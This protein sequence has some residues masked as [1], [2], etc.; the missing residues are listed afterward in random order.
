MPSIMTSSS[1]VRT[2]KFL[3][4]RSAGFSPLRSG[5]KP[6]LRR[7]LFLRIVR[8]RP[9]PAGDRR[10]RRLAFL[11]RLATLGQNA[12]RTARM[13]AARR[14]PFAATHGMA[15][16]VHRGAAIVRLAA[17]PAF[18]T[19]LAQADVHVVGVAQ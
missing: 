3:H 6:A 10:I 16:R 2:Y 13:P 18:A 12:R 19:G 7:L 15:D 4:T 11:A 17:Q 1:P 14:S 5:L 9:A 8:P